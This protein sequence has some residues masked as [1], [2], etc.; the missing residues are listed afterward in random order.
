MSALPDPTDPSLYSHWAD[1]VV[2]FCDTDQA[3]HVNN[4]AIAAY[5]ETGRLMFDRE[6]IGATAEGLEGEVFQAILA[7][8]TVNY[9]LESFW[10]GKVRVGTRLIR[11]G[12]SSLTTAHGV[13]REHGCIAT[14]TCVM[15]N[16]ADGRS[17]PIGPQMRERLAGLLP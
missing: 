16:R 9:L 4:V 14:S 13:F 7:N 1:D 15:V 3:G 6:V 17:A 11:I 10:P 12:T 8:L 2:R 5:V